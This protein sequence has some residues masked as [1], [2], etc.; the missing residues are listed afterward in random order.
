MKEQFPIIGHYNPAGRYPAFV[1]PVC[2]QSDGRRAIAYASGLVE[3]DEH[4][5]PFV[6]GGPNLSDE[7]PTFEPGSEEIFATS[8]E[9]VRIVETADSSRFCL[10]LFSSGLLDDCD[11]FLAIPLATRA[12]DDEIFRKVIRSALLEIGHDSRFAQLWYSSQR[13]RNEILPRWLPQ[14]S[15]ELFNGRSIARIA[16]SFDTLPLCR[17]ACRRLNNSV[18]KFETDAPWLAAHPFDLSTHEDPPPEIVLADPVTSRFVLKRRK[19]VD[20]AFAG[21]AEPVLAVSPS[22]AKGLREN[23]GWVDFLIEAVAS[24]GFKWIRP[25]SETPVG[26]MLDLGIFEELREA[27]NRFPESPE[28]LLKTLEE[29]VISNP[30]TDGEAIPQAYADERWRVGAIAALR[31]SCIAAFSGIER[32]KR[33]RILA[34]GTKRLPIPYFAYQMS[35]AASIQN[36]FGRLKDFFVSEIGRSIV[37]SFG[38]SAEH[39][40]FPFV[41]RRRAM[42]AEASRQMSGLQRPVFVWIV[43]DTSESMEGQKLEEAK[44]GITLLLGRLKGL[45]GDHAGL[46]TFSDTVQLQ[47]KFGPLSQVVSQIIERT[48]VL[49][50]D[51][52]T[53]LVDGIMAALRGMP[54]SI[55]AIRAIVV[56]TDGMENSS[57]SS[58]AELFSALQS[59]EFGAVPVYCLSYGV[60]ADR[61]F[62]E[63]I[64]GV[65]GGVAYSGS[66]SGIEELFERISYHF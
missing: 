2:V 45:R 63:R 22:L 66:Y 36:A 38:L 13:S 47:V 51:G 35:G 1:V 21:I 39:F 61:L 32:S 52:R 23:S 42:A 33:P 4:A 9:N 34:S 25:R 20:A 16:C 18:A 48:A 5:S 19:P 3:I 56:L 31:H 46:L 40:D 49:G 44:L 58:A 55:E 10:E 12:G 24:P 17:A 26:E 28:E 37:D 41:Q 54:P 62:L 8:E 11:P 43:L 15:F 29:R 30:A 6:P 50:A 59:H 27:R 14:E 64:A 53:A 57:R 7:T 65:S 60:D